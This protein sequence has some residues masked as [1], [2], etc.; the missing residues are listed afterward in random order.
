ME[1][2]VSG[3]NGNSIGTTKHDIVPIYFMK[4]ARSGTQIVDVL[5]KALFDNKIKKLTR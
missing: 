4:A 5:A 2:F 3:L 1:W